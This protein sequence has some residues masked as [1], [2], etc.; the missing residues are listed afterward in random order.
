MGR[1]KAKQ[2]ARKEVAMREQSATRLQSIQR[3]RHARRKAKRAAEISAAEYAA[4]SRVQSIQRGRMGRVKAKREVEVERRV[5]AMAAAFA[6]PVDFDDQASQSS[7]QGSVKSVRF[8]HDPYEHE[9][10]GDSVRKNATDEASPSRHR[11]LRKNSHGYE[12]DNDV[13]HEDNYCADRDYHVDSVPSSI[14]IADSNQ[15]PFTPPSIRRLERLSLGPRGAMIQEELKESSTESNLSDKEEISVVA[16]TFEEE[17]GWT[18]DQ[19]ESAAPEFH[20]RSIVRSAIARA[21]ATFITEKRAQSLIPMAWAVTEDEELS[22]DTDQVEEQAA[23]GAARVAALNLRS[24]TDSSSSLSEQSEQPRTLSRAAFYNV[25]LPSPTHTGVTFERSF[26]IDKRRSLTP[27]TPIPLVKSFCS[28]HGIDLSSLGP[29]ADMQR[30]GLYVLLKQVN[31]P[32]TA[33]E[34]I[35]KPQPA[36]MLIQVLLKKQLDRARHGPNGRS[37][38]Q[39]QT[40]WLSVRTPR[41]PAKSATS[42]AQSPRFA[43]R[44]VRPASSPARWALAKAA[45]A[46]A[47]RFQQR[48]TSVTP[49]EAA[50]AAAQLAVTNAIKERI[51]KRKEGTMKDEEG[52]GSGDDSDTENDIAK[53]P[54]LT[55]DR[56]DDE[57][58]EGRSPRS[59]R[60]TPGLIRPGNAGSRNPTPGRMRDPNPGLTRPEESSGSRGATPGSQRR[61]STPG[62]MRQEDASSRGPT[63]GRIRRAGNQRL[64]KAKRRVEELKVEIAAL[65]SGSPDDEAVQDALA[66]SREQLT[67]AL[68]ELKDAQRT[69]DESAL[70]D[71]AMK[72]ELESDLEAE[73]AE[74]KKE[75]E[76]CEKQTSEI[77]ALMKEYKLEITALKEA[78]DIPGAKA[79][80]AEYRK[81][82]AEKDRLQSRI[83]EL[84]AGGSASN[85]P[86]R[87]RAATRAAGPF[88]YQEL[89]TFARSC[90]V[91]TPPPRNIRK[92]LD[93]FR[94]IINLCPVAIILVDMRH[95]GLP[96]T[97]C[98]PAFS[99]LTGYTVEEA[100]G[101]N[102]KFLQGKKT[103]AA[104][105]RCMTEAI[106][107]RTVQNLN[108]LNFKKDGSQFQNNLSLH[109][110]ENENGEYKYNVGV[111]VDGIELKKRSEQERTAL[112]NLRNS[113]PKVA[114]IDVGERRSA[115]NSKEEPAKM[116]PVAVKKGSE[117]LDAKWKEVLTKLTRLMYSLDWKDA[118]EH[119]MTVE[120]ARKGLHEWILKHS[121]VNVVYFEILYSVEIRLAGISNNTRKGTLAIELGMK[122][123]EGECPKEMHKLMDALKEKSEIAKDELAE[124][125]LPKFVQSK[126]CLPVIDHMLGIGSSPQLPPDILHHANPN[127]QYSGPELEW[128][129]GIAQFGIALNV[130]ISI[131]DTSQ[132]ANP[133]IFVN[134][135]FCRATGF[136]R[137]DALG[138]NCR[139]L[140]GPG[141]EAQSVKVISTAL[142]DST[143]CVV[144]IS[145][146]RQSG[147]PFAMLLALRPI[148]DESGKKRFCIGLHMEITS[149][150]SLKTLVT[151]VSKLIKLFPSTAPF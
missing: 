72:Q 76:A 3:G 109:P 12:G 5:A 55:S 36:G 143:D 140:Q 21:A 145:N 117:A 74:R 8:A 14:A 11:L 87:I 91:G 81:M 110:V 25:Q 141:T 98:N 78:G 112:N 71:A 9:E 39:G 142:R 129:Q 84:D 125:C 94:H 27:S 104:A 38:T 108:V 107:G 70:K 26:M 33:K 113:V 85:T 114:T 151:K 132:M 18:S 119:L 50:A 73:K 66:A 19:Q 146:Y 149:S 54:R 40:S 130:M 82:Q 136:S 131:S 2:E 120:A 60:G 49:A 61:A 20:V 111:L 4:A 47:V 57:A 1:V 83:S 123:L 77:K 97:L 45:P 32:E 17:M 93:V 64:E 6:A 53:P 22:E 63:P 31:W 139:F 134:N 30:W 65:E 88:L 115:R 79:K 59:T 122:F 127:Q 43:R 62:L 41:P 67:N 16:S 28:E 96:I 137:G 51:K 95:E 147:E 68:V 103:T 15:W 56:G 89:A 10:D 29:T 13:E 69:V 48:K 34:L 42:S 92:W 144:K 128:L 7:R 44:K 58:D 102:C 116:T 24:R 99:K 80:L 52:K 105:V 124:R 121:A 106:K 75:K 135:A 35:L 100:T 138:K 133:L 148:V 37:S 46:I 90:A 150:R 101:K 118:L 23:S 126:A 86:S